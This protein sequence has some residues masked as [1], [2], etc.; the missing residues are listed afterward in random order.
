[1]RGGSLMSVELIKDLLKIDQTV[2][3]D[4]IQALVEGE[5]SLPEIKPSINKVLKVDGDVEITGTKL[6]QD[7][8]IVSGIVNFKVLYNA[9]D[10]KQSIH[11]LEASTNFREEV[12]MSN[13]NEGMIA[14]I[15]AKVEH[16]DYSLV[17]ESTISVK[18]V[19]DI[20]GKVQTNNNIDIVR[21]IK[22]AEGLQILKERIQY[23]D[24]I[25]TN[26]SSTLVKEAF[27]ELKAEKD[28]LTLKIEGLEASLEAI[29]QEKHELE[30]AKDLT[31]SGLNENIVA[32]TENLFI[33]E[34]ERDKKD[35]EIARLKEEISELSLENERLSKE[36]DELKKEN[37]GLR[38]QINALIE[39]ND[40][41]ESTLENLQEEK[42]DFENYIQELISQIEQLSNPSIPEEG[43]DDCNLNEDIDDSENLDLSEEVE[44]P[45]ELIDSLQEDQEAVALLLDR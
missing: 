16:I 32:L 41:L 29:K 9:N 18:T 27:E 24:I 13:I 3:K 43:L 40:S 30:E 4:Q 11:S 5:I 8:I 34:S 22:G 33:V 37:S 25:G 15:K 44:E 10:E 12:D 19:L 31:I 23:N 20:D 36:N 6:S 28:E 17:D 45:V 7:K 26:N 39:S 38:A 1:M 42:A 2:G 35:E 14:E 21:D